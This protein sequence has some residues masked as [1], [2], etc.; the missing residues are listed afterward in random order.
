MAMELVAME[1]VAMV[2]PPCHQ[3][4]MKHSTTQ[5][6]PN[7]MYSTGHIQK[8]HEEE[9]K[10]NTHTHTGKEERSSKTNNARIINFIYTSQVDLICKNG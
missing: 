9:R 6:L 5:Y 4:K 1:L 10:K 8:K 3:S 2:A 7:R